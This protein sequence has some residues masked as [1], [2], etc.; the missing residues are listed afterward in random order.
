MENPNL[1]AW[2]NQSLSDWL[3]TTP[4]AELQ[5]AAPLPWGITEREL[6]EM[7]RGWASQGRSRF[8]FD[9]FL[10]R[11]GIRRLLETKPYH[12]RLLTLLRGTP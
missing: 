1:S 10:R 6:E 9:L 12:A 11:A 8:E 3:Q 2:M 5:R 7:T 4:L